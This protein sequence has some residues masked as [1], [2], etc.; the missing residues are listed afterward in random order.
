MDETTKQA[1]NTFVQ[2]MIVAAQDS[3]K[4]TADQAPLVVQEWLRWQLAQSVVV[5]LWFLGA[6]IALAVLSRRWFKN[7][8]I[9]PETPLPLFSSFMAV[10]AFLLAMGNT[11]DA[12]KVWLAP[13]VVVLEQF[14]SLVK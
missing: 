8:N 10:G 6:A 5:A 14:I 2:Q 3:A 4:W 11:L 13:R 7:D 12:L 1:L 9:W